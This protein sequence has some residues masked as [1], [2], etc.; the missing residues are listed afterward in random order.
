MTEIRVC[1]IDEI[2]DP[3]ARGI[4]LPDADWPSSGFVV[5]KGDAVYAY[6]NVCPHAGNP[7]HWKQ[8][9]FLTRNRDLIMCA[10]HGAL[11]ELATGLCVAGPCPGKKLTALET[12]VEK[13]SVFVRT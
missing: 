10:K 1:H 4:D 13:G 12:R 11:F 7:L 6:R 8:D 3:G 5:R 9:A 2:D